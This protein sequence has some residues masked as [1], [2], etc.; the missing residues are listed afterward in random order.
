MSIVLFDGWN[1]L[2]NSKSTSSDAQIEWLWM[3]LVMGGGGEMVHIIFV[4]SLEDGHDQGITE[5]L[6][7][8]PM[9]IEFSL[10]YWLKECG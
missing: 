1:P 3:T 2:C 7:Y 10:I 6:C 9:L 5:A 8:A 4:S